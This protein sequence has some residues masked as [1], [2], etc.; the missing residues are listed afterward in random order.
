MAFWSKKPTG[1]GPAPAPGVKAPG[2]PSPAAVAACL[3]CGDALLGAGEAGCTLCGR[4]GAHPERC[5]RGHAVCDACLDGPAADVVERTCAASDERDPVALALRL[6]RHPRLRLGPADHDQLVPSVLVAAWST[7]RNEP[8]KRAARVS[9]ARARARAAPTVKLGR[10]DGRGAAA[11]AGAFVSLAAEASRGGPDAALVDR[12]IARAQ[13]IIGSGDDAACM[14]RNAL[15]AVL[16]AARFAKDGLGAEL[17]ARGF[18]CEN[19]GRNPTC[20]GAGCPFNR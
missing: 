16:A 11:G 14:R 8:G 15:V 7:T 20:V 1:T 13:A 5:G 6:L 2:A 3:V 9:E 19:A 17:S 18:A 4:T 10:P 12:M